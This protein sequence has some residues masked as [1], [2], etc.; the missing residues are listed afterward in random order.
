MGGRLPYGVWTIETGSAVCKASTFP[1]DSVLSA[2]PVGVNLKASGRLETKSVF[3]RVIWRGTEEKTG[4]ASSKRL[5]R[6]TA[7]GQGG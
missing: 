6:D 2:D 3:V 7:V 5:V 4:L 1:T